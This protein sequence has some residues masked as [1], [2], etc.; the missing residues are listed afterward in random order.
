M[1]SCFWNRPKKPQ[2][3]FIV[4]IYSTWVIASLGVHIFQH[5][6]PF[7]YLL[8]LS[9]FSVLCN[10]PL[11]YLFPK[12]SKNSVTQLSTQMPTGDRRFS[13]LLPWDTK[14]FASSVALFFQLLSSSWPEFFLQAEN[15]HAAVWA[16]AWQGGCKVS[17]RAHRRSGILELRE[18]VKLYRETSLLIL[19]ATYQ[20]TYWEC[21]E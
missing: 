11:C 10:I 17:R 20:A 5:L 8:I 2:K 4:E 18:R 14:L 1:S 9:Y 3:P 6:S 19:H 16:M 7:L 15:S 13:S 21:M 12:N